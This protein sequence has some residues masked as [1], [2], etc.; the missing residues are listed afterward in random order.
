MKHRLLRHVVGVA[1][2][3]ISKGGDRLRCV[4]TSFVR[5]RDRNSENFSEVEQQFPR[6]F[7]LGSVRRYL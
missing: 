3:K 1:P 6:G 7:C 4:L 2:Q 5:G